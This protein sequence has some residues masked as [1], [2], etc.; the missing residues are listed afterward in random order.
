MKYYFDYGVVGGPDNKK[1]LRSLPVRKMD[2]RSEYYNGTEEEF[3]RIYGTAIRPCWRPEFWSDKFSPETVE[4]ATK[5]FG[6]LCKAYI[7]DHSER[8]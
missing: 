2:H 3:N 1:R 7:A 8:S 5:E 4:A 6:P